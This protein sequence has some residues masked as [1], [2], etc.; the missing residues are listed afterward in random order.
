METRIYNQETLDKYTKA[1][2]EYAKLWNVTDAHVIQIMTSVMLHRDGLRP[3]GG[4]VQSV[5]DNK[6]DLAVGRADDTC[7]KYLK[8]IVA[9]KQ[10]CHVR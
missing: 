3:G 2:E 4:F 6:L 7:A 5:V 1:A 8:E 9:T 10:N